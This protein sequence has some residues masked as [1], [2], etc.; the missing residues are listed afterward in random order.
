MEKGQVRRG[1]F[2][3][4]IDKKRI[5]LACLVV[6]ILF[7]IGV[8]AEEVK[9]VHRSVLNESKRI[10]LTFDDGP[11]PHQTKEILDVLDRYDVKA[12]FFMVG[13]NVKNYPETAALVI[14][15]GHEIGNHTL[16]HRHLQMMDDGAVLAELTGCED[17]LEELCEYRPHLFRPPEGAIT[18]SVLRCAK[19]EDYELVLWSID[20]RDWETKNADKIV[21]TVLRQIKPG[22]II[23]MHDYIGRGSKTPQALERLLPILLERG[24]E[25]VTVSRLLNLD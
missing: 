5:F 25:P 8:N 4:T 24:Y 6:I 12:T 3:C 13:V 7:V 15:N 21:D 19:K 9:G 18:E 1:E 16:T 17:A 10:A 22:D 23:L 11:H 20:T 14:K 2:P